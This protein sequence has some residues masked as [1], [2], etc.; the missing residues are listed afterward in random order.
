MSLTSRLTS[1]RQTLQT[2]VTWLTITVVAA[3]VVVSVLR[4]GIPTLR[5]DWRTPAYPGATDTWLATFFEPWLDAGIGAPQP[6]PTFYLVG[7][8]VWPFHL[9]KAPLA[10]LS[11]FIFASALLTVLA[12]KALARNLGAPWYA[13]LAVGAFCVLNPWVYAKYVAGHIV[14]VLAFGFGL[15]LIAELLRDRPRSPHLILWSAL[16]VTQIEFCALAGPLLLIWSIRNRRFA[17]LAAFAIALL[18]IALGLAGRYEAILNTPYLLPWQADQSV[19]PLSGLLMQGYNYAGAFQPFSVVL[20]ALVLIAISGAMLLRRRAAVIVALLA[21]GCWLLATGTTWFFAP[22]YRFLVLNLPQSG[23]FR[24]LY[25]LIAVLVAG[26]AIGL[27]AAAA[28]SKILGTLVTVACALLVLPWLLSPVSNFFVPAGDLPQIALP[29]SPA[30]RVALFPA[31]QPLSFEGRGSGVDPDAYIQT[32]LAHPIN[33]A[34][35]TFPLTSAL[36]NA[37][38]GDNRELEALGVTQITERPYFSSDD[39]A[40]R[41]QVAALPAQ[42]RVTSQQLLGLPLLSLVSD[43]VIAAAPFDPAQDAVFV[44]DVS[45]IDLT[46]FMPDR[47]TLDPRNAWIDIRLLTLAHPEIQSPLGGVYTSGTVAHTVPDRSNILAWTDGAIVDNA[48]N[49]LAMPGNGL[50]WYALRRPTQS[51]RC[52]RDCALVAAANIPPHLH[53]A[54]LNTRITPVDGTELRPWLWKIRLPQGGGATLRFAE[55]YDR[56]WIAVAGRRALPH[57]RLAG[58]LN[59]WN[60][61]GA[62]DTTVYL[63]ETLSAAQFVLEIGAALAVIGMLVFFATRS[64]HR[65]FRTGR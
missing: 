51:V 45:D 50:R 65:D 36:V 9:L 53:D 46:R 48:G 25:D 13:A 11:M 8:V 49:V 59:A 22:A 14:M 18:P 57:V 43:P 47:S 24:E 42:P 4:Y 1:S 56:F 40:L 12:G 30:S 62:G 16:A 35:T 64:V 7:F 32:G 19:S 17:P 61:A 31:F 33:Q 44:G 29:A 52:I 58:S 38:R 63:I 34:E 27:S 28:R 20:W 10:I 55:T 21:L 54:A 2:L 39:A 60:I 15:A 41:M 23:I 6:Y 37:E 5:H 3:I 26:Y